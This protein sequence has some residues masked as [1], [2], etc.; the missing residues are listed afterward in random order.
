MKYK[1]IR[2]YHTTNGTLYCEEIVKQD[3]NSTLE[4]HIR[5]KDN[6]GRVWF[7]PDNYMKKI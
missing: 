7:V 4:N 2:D 5:V 6:M 3:N 1:V